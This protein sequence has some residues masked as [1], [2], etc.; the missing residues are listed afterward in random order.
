M[1]LTVILLITTLPFL[2]VIGDGILK[3]V[4]MLQSPRFQIIFVMAIWPLVLNIFESWVIDHVIKRKHG[5]SSMS[6]S[7]HIPLPSD[8]NDHCQDHHIA[9]GG[10]RLSTSFEM[11]TESTIGS[12]TLA[13]SSIFPGAQGTKR[14]SSIDISEFELEIVSDGED[15]HLKTKKSYLDTPFMTGPL[16]APISADRDRQ[17]PSGSPNSDSISAEIST[18]EEAIHK[19][20]KPHDD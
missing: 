15:S 18:D 13:G 17:R 19:H 4:Q 11:T 3:P 5:M 8:D 14:N 10:S 12:R 16:L 7:G 6:A 20:Q 1:K 9:N 2:V